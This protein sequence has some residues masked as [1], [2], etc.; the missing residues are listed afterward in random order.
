MIL[1]L[2]TY[3]QKPA[4]PKIKKYCTLLGTMTYP[5]PNVALCVC[6]DDFPAFPFGRIQVGYVIVAWRIF[7]EK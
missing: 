7:F 1:L 6:V 5:L 2:T 4:S 3:E